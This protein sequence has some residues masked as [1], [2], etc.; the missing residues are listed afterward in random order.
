MQ[1][2]SSTDRHALVKQPPAEA[3]QQPNEG[4]QS[5]SSGNDSSESSSSQMV[6]QQQPGGPRSTA[7]HKLA[8]SQAK[9]RHAVLHKPE[10][11]DKLRKPSAKLPAVAA[12]PLLS[13]QQAADAV[14]AVLKP[15]YASKLVSKDQFKA[16][17][18]SATHVLVDQAAA[19]KDV[20]QTVQTCLAA[21]GLG[22]VVAQAL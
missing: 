13:K 22:D 2:D 16:V 12:G 18:Q 8:A 14:R 3:L 1:H 6:H 9:A 7:N 4:W 20:K 19:G 10:Q 17:A 11:A 5:T 15:L 21:V